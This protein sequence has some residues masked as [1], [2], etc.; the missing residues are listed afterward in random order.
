MLMDLV[1]VLKWVKSVIGW[2]LYT[3]HLSDINTIDTVQ[4][5]FGVCQNWQSKTIEVLLTFY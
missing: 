1:F 3:F 4:I 2:A 5:Q